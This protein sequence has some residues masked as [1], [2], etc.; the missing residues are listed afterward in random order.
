LD[1]LFHL[2][3]SQVPD[4]GGNY[5]SMQEAC[6]RLAA[7]HIPLKQCGEHQLKIGYLN[8]F[9]RQ[10]ITTV[11]AKRIS[12]EHGGFHQFLENLKKAGLTKPAS[13][14]HSSDGYFR[15]SR[16]NFILKGG[17]V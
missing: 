4:R 10:G 14:S 12:T 2:V 6:S 9:P 15:P 3:S 7:L 11:D 13:A 8:Y 1:N 17:W 16:R 5:P